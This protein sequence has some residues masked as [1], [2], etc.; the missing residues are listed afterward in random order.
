MNTLNCRIS[1]QCGATSF[2]KTID[3]NIEN[4]LVLI[5]KIL[6]VNKII[7]IDHSIQTLFD[8]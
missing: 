1:R 8:E 6:S 7:K 2:F 3:F 4:P 5:C